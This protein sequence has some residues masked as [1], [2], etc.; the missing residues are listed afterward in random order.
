MC[1]GERIKFIRKAIHLTQIIFAEEL[2]VDQTYISALEKSKNIPSE[3]LILSICRAFSVNYNWLKN[4]D[5]EIYSNPLQVREVQASY[6]TSDRILKSWIDRLV[7][8]FEEGDE[9]KIEA[10]KA[11][12]RALDPAT[13]K[14]DLQKKEGQSIGKKAM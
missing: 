8:I 5:G 2:G 7:R 1:I 14:Q 4:G 3:Q 13:Q 11:S 6:K 12:L 9:K 10:I